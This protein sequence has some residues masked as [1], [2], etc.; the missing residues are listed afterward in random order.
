[1]KYVM[2]I[3]AAAAAMAL[4]SQ[5]ALADGCMMRL[6]VGASTKM[7]AS[8]RQEALLATDGETVQVILRTHFRAGPKELA[9][10]V[11]VPGKPANIAAADDA[12]FASLEQATA[13]RFVRFVHRGGGFG[14][15]C[16]APGGDVAM[17]ASS[18]VVEET[19]EAGIFK[20][21]VLSATDGG[22]LTKWLNDNKY[23][24]PIG[25]DRVFKQYVREGWYWLAMRVRPE[26]T[27][28]ATLAPHPI[29]YTYRSATLV[30]PMVISQ[31]SA[32]LKNEILL[33]VVGRGRYA[34][35]NWAN[36]DINGITKERSAITRRAEA[37]SGTNYEQLF[38][39]AAEAKGGKLFVTEFSR[40]TSRFYGDRDALTKSINE[41][42]LASL[43]DQATLTRLR[44]V[45]TPKA[46]D[47]DVGLLPADWGDV[48]NVYRL[49]S[50]VEG[51][52][53]TGAVG[54]VAALGALCLGVCLTKNTGWP[55][56]GGIVC[57][58]LG[59][60][61]MAMM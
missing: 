39:A 9:W 18:V 28:A 36:D 3:A 24:V 27:N 13:P 19:G 46:M 1:M 12:I 52:H 10:V 57:I 59:A 54:A 29:T 49:T 61:A 7:V 25:A 37:P 45:M 38:E 11:P 41:H 31:L 43:G 5:A 50:A 6:D 42:I 17:P 60:A 58:V 15:G 30:Y 40:P 34:C 22:A 20:Y 51:G 44:A 21:V 23:H 14:C 26:A 33:Y 2:S 35:G 53:S 56:A 8:P 47:S 4:A 16:S 55:R 32:D 48:E